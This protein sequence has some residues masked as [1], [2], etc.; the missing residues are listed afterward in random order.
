MQA[1]LWHRLAGW[2]ASCLASYLLSSCCCSMAQ[3]LA[4]R[5]VSLFSY[6][7]A[8]QH[9]CKGA[10]NEPLN[11]LLK[12]PARKR[13]IFKLIERQTA[14]FIDSAGATNTNGR[15]QAATFQFD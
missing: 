2:L 8:R 6:L 1:E 5:P 4:G 13:E 12:S 11:G 7:L 3:W 15:Q 10:A 9:S 14:E